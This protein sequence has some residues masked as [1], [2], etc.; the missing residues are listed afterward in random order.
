MAA[1]RSDTSRSLVRRP[2]IARAAGGGPE[3]SKRRGSSS[4]G[5]KG[6]SGFSGAPRSRPRPSS[7][8]QQGPQQQ[9]PS[10]ARKAAPAA[11]QPPLAPPIRMRALGELS[12]SDRMPPPLWSTFCGV[13]NGLWCGITAAYSPF[14]GKCPA[15]RWKARGGVATRLQ[16]PSLLRAQPASVTGAPPPAPLPSLAQASPSPWLWTRRASR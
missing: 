3:S 12:T 5:G 1:A 16:P 6:G 10:V 2:S 15:G 7:G 8:R 4:K 11:E 14:T 9:Q 13:T